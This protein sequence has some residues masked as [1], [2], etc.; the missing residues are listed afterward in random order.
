[1]K[2]LIRALVLAATAALPLIAQRPARATEDSA[3]RARLEGEIRRNFARVVRNRVELTDA[4]M[5][6]LGPISKRYEQQRRQ[7][8]IEERD[9]RMSLRQTLRDESTADTAQ[10]SKMLRTLV[11][12]QQRRSHV[13]AAEQIELATIMSPIQRAK[14]MAM[15]EQIRRRLEQMRQRRMQLAPGDGEAPLGPPPRRRPPF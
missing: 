1:V 15:Q 10:V 4:Q 11:E 6:K 3:S 12:L 13:L 5:A 2:Q 9:T 14:Y 7:L 8:Q